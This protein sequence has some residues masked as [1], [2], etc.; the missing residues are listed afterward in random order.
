[1]CVVSNNLI[2]I[3][4]VNGVIK[5]WSHDDNTFLNSFDA[6]SDVISS[7]VAINGPNN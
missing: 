7:L 2:A 5:L 1:M 3:G 6:H 4:D